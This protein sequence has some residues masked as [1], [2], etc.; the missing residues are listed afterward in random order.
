MTRKH[1]TKNHAIGEGNGFY[2]PSSSP[3][4]PSA[5]IMDDTDG[6]LYPFAI[7]LYN[8]AAEFEL[9][10]IYAQQSGDTDTSFM[11]TAYVEFPFDTRFAKLNESLIQ[12]SRI[13]SLSTQDAS[14]T[15]AVS[16]GCV[17]ITGDTT[18]YAPLPTKGATLRVMGMDASGAPVSNTLSGTYFGCSFRGVSHN[19]VVFTGS[20]LLMNGRCIDLIGVNNSVWQIVGTA[21]WTK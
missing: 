12:K 11:S 19:G 20:T 7:K 2:F 16:A 17:C 3:S 13:A 21:P 5:V 18:W 6:A 1:Y 8:L 4:A 9:M 14:G 15:D 10:R